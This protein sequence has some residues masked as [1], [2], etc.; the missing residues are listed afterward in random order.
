MS[1]AAPARGAFGASAHPVLWI[2]LL[3]G[4]S[5][6]LAE[7][8]RGL[9]GENPSSP[10]STLLAPLL[11][12]LCVWQGRGG[13]DP[14][15]RSG[16]LLIGLGLLLELVGIALGVW[17]VAWLGFPIA[18]LGLALWTGR[19][20]WRVAA[21]TFGLVAV[22]VTVQAAGSPG[23]E[24]A[25]LRGAC[26]PWRAVG[27]AFECTGPVASLGATRLELG[28]GDLGWTLAWVLAQLG[29][30]RA[31]YTGAPAAE[32]LRRALAFASA[33]LLLQPVA[34]GVALGLLAGGFERAA[35]PWLSEGVWL[36]CSAVI[37]LWT[38]RAPRATP[39]P[40]AS[41]DRARTP[42]RDG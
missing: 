24:S 13:V 5:P 36:L 2:A 8:T 6:T 37:V 3:A 21:L 19:P 1:D 40:A 33:T 15:R 18:A 35:R 41:R 38:I 29:W 42:R 25:L 26:A 39:P 12:V 7:Y 34:V 23:P 16:G 28:P 31:V 27:V 22:P 4:F 20:S 14:P 32:A 17:T 10:L 9:G 30:F 11:L